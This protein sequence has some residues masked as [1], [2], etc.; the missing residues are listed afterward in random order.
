MTALLNASAHV[1]ETLRQLSSKRWIIA[2][3]GGKD[4]SALLCLVFNNLVKLKKFKPPSSVEV[5]YCDTR[6]E[7]PI[8]D[9]YVKRLLRQLRAEI[10]TLDLSLSVK[11]VSPP[12]ERTF[13]ARVIGRGYPPPTN[14]FRWCTKELRIRPVENY[15]GAHRDAVVALGIRQN[16]SRQRDRFL[17]SHKDPFWMVAENTKNELLYYT[18]IRQLSTEDVW[19]IIYF[20]RLPYALDRKSLWDL[21]ASAGN[22][23]PLVRSAD[24]S[25]CASGRFGCWTCTVGSVSFYWISGMTDQ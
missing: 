3:S 12:S 2:F 5:L 9:A 19:D 4:S 11:I 18:P 24:N 1:Y 22:D 21:Y 13:F 20:S 6:T 8:I 16:E 15:L 17:L 14:S 10:A 7:N 25:P 23:C